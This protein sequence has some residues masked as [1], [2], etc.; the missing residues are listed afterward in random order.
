MLFACVALTLLGAP[1]RSPVALVVTRRTN[2]SLV[3]GQALAREYTRTLEGMGLTIDKGP[4][5]ALS[6]LARLSVKD[7]ASCQGRRACVAQLGRELR[8]DYVLGLSVATLEGDRSVA[9]ELIKVADEATL[10]K[11]SHLLAKGAGP[12]AQL[13]SATAA[14]LRELLGPPAAPPDAPVAE[15]PKPQVTLTPVEAAP[16]TPVAPV[17]SERPAAVRAVPV[18]LLGSGAALMLGGVGALAG[19]ATLHGTLGLG[20]VDVDGRIR[21]GLSQSQAEHLSQDATGLVIAGLVGIAAG[22]GLAA[23]GVATW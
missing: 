18:V 10:L 8:V 15:P 2:L 12:T 20:S 17:I 19:G 23:A 3:D 11:D 7:T 4:D 1:A 21:S 6:E 16:T 13:L 14:K 9:L 5:A 22:A